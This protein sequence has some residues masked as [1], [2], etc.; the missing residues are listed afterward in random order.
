M[1]AARAW[2]TPELIKKFPKFQSDAMNTQPLLLAFGPVGRHPATVR[3]GRYVG[4]LVQEFYAD[5][6]PTS[7]MPDYWM[8]CPTHPNHPKD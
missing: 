4:G 6:S 2:F 8:P 5:G 3:M 1:K 7:Q